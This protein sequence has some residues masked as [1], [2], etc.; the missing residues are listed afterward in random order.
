MAA[1]SW[2]AGPGDPPEPCIASILLVPLREQLILGVI[3]CNT[4]VLSHHFGTLIRLMARDNISR[5]D[6][7]DML[8]LEEVEI[9]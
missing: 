6:K 8:Q 5:L 4:G 2:S 7:E 9:P 3:D 1:H